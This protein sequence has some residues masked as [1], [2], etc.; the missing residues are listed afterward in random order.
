LIFLSSC[1]AQNHNH[2][3]F[4]YFGRSL[5]ETLAS[6]G[7]EIPKVITKAFEYLDNPKALGEEGLFRVSAAKSKVIA[8]I[9]EIDSGKDVDLKELKPDPEVVTDVVKHFF[10][11]LPEPLLTYELY[12]YFID[13]S[14][15]LF[16][17]SLLRISGAYL[18]FICSVGNRAR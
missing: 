13:S 11:E 5:A 2:F 15:S 17:F 10:R 3:V 6:G 4:Q 12:D 14:G 8:L 1:F 9:S 16:C 7:T 18:S